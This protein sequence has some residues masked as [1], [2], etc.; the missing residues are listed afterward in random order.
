VSGSRGTSGL[1]LASLIC[2]CLIIPFTCL[3][4]IPAIICGILGL[5]SIGKNPGLGGRG[6]AIGGIILGCISVIAVALMV[7]VLVPAIPS[8]TEKAGK[9][10][11]IA[12]SGVVEVLLQKYSQEHNGKYPNSLEE[13][14]EGNPDA[15]K[16]KAMIFEEGSGQPKW[17]LTPGLSVDSP[18]ATVLVVSKKTYGTGPDA[19]RIVVYVDGKVDLQKE[20][21]SPPSD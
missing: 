18:P 19:V 7:F 2:G 3:T 8:I 6:M 1:A 11:A 15:Q 21:E 17:T 13:L 20:S 4:G 5:I 9:F 14:L 16:F 12:E 10:S